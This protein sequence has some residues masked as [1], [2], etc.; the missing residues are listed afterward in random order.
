MLS[1]DPFEDNT[2]IFSDDRIYPNRCNISFDKSGLA[3]D[4]DDTLW[5]LSPFQGT[6]KTT[7]TN[8][9]F[10]KGGFIEISGDDYMYLVGHM[11]KK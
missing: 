5:A 6:M 9:I 10:C 11:K 1:S 8:L 4:A 3:K 7:P 2:L